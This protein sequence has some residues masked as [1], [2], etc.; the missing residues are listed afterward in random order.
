M[1]TGEQ[2]YELI[3]PH[4]GIEFHGETNADERSL[5]NLAELDDLLYFLHQDLN[6]LH[7]QVKHR[8]EYSAI[9]LEKRLKP[10]QVSMKILSDEWEEKEEVEK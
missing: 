2:I 8:Y 4:L 1:I 7:N 9:K 3:K 6:N 10:I 5:K